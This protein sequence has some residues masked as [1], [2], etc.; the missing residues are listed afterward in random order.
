MD[1]Q[2]DVE[3][4]DERDGPDPWPGI[5]E[6]LARPLGIVAHNDAETLRPESP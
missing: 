4:F 3:L 2:M 6:M 5:V 1:Q